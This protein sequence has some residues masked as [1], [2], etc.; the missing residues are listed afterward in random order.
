MTETAERRNRTAPPRHP[1]IRQTAGLRYNAIMQ[2]RHPRL[3]SAALALAAM[4]AAI[5]ILPAGCATSPAM[6]AEVG[7][8]QLNWL[9]V[10]YRPADARRSPCYIYVVG[11]GYV[12]FS[13]GESPL[14]TNSFATDTTH[15]RWSD[16]TQEKIGISPEE[17]R[18]IFQRFAD[19]GLLSEPSRPKRGQVPADPRGVAS[20]HY[21]IDGKERHCITA[22]PQLIN[23]VE[24]MVRSLTAEVQ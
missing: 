4:P 3:L 7:D 24:A 6:P 20:F 16:H 17:A 5:L 21:R 18:A 22:N 2:K 15:A 13:T 8:S 1:G 10:R 14:V 11:A 23:L 9:N 19:A 12:H